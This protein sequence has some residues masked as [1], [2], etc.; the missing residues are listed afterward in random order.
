MNGV[1][2]RWDCPK[3]TAHVLLASTAKAVLYSYF[4]MGISDRKVC[5]IISAKH[6]NL[7][8]I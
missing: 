1:H 4:S 7:E 2:Y 8:V 3:Q 6:N 5:E